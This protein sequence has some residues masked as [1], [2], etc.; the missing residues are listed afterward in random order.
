MKKN[1]LAARGLPLAAI[2]I[3]TILL[4]AARV[5][6]QAGEPF[7]E[8][9]RSLG[10]FGIAIELVRIL[11]LPGMI[12]LIWYFDRKQMGRMLDQYKRDM[13]KMGTLVRKTQDIAKG[14]EKIAEGLNDEIRISTQVLTTLVEKIETNQYC[15]KVRLK[16]VKSRG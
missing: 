14:Y 7:S 13:V 6:A 16:V 5:Y 8:F 3:L 15:P 12:F 9:L 4:V 11:G 2:T 10:P 1:P